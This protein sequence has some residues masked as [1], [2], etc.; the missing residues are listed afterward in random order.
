[1]A[2]AR[3]SS[4]RHACAWEAGGLTQGGRRVEVVE[5]CEGVGVIDDWEG[6]GEDGVDGAC[7]C[8]VRPPGVLRRPQ[9]SVDSQR[10]R[11]CPATDKLNVFVGA[12]RGAQGAGKAD[13]Q[14]VPGVDARRWLV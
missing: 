4:A 13:A 6:G 2:E 5:A 14:R 1:M 12:S 11:R 7:F 8:H 9:P 10:L 3:A